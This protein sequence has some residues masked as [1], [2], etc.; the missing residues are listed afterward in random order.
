MSGCWRRDRALPPCP[1]CPACAAKD[2]LI[3]ALAERVEAQ[4]DLLSKRA[5][6]ATTEGARHEQPEQ[7]DR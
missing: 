3:R 5:E 2:E 1:P 6:K 4:S 7:P